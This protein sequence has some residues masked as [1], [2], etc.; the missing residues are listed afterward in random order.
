MKRQAGLSIRPVGKNDFDAVRRIT[1]EAY[2]SAGHIDESHPYLRVLADVERRAGCAQ[3]WV[4]EVDREAKGSV[5]LTFPGQPFSEVARE[6]ELEFRMLA[7]DPAAQGRGVGRAM[8]E[9]IL[10][11]ARALDLV[12][13]VVLTTAPRMVAAHR[14][15]E[16]LGFRR[17]PERDWSFDGAE[18]LWV[19]RCS[20]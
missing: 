20:L 17:V 13:A 1:L 18:L 5:M 3:V 16:S 4:A 12:H 2:L 7:V 14:L 8:V 19:F 10:A 6:Q 9:W 15:Y 11:H